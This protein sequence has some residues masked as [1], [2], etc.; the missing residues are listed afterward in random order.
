M[1]LTD[2]EPR[3]RAVIH[4]DRL[5]VASL[6]NLQWTLVLCPPLQSRTGQTLAFK[7]LKN[8]SIWWCTCFN[9]SFHQTQLCCELMTAGTKPHRRVSLVSHQPFNLPHLFRRRMYYY[10]NEYSQVAHPCVH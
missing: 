5:Q 7:N 1:G 4:Y 6:V 3:K 10:W 8:K 9:V 2:D